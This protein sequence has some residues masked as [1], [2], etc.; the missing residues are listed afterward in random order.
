M[1]SFYCL[2]I[3]TFLVAL[4]GG[5]MAQVVVSGLVKNNSGKPIPSVSITLK[6]RN[7]LV[8]GFAIT[9]ASGTYRIGYEKASV[10]DTLT[11]EAVAVNYNRYSFP[12][13]TAKQVSDFV[14]SPAVTRLPDVVVKSRQMLRKE[15]DTL[16][17]DVESFST[18]Q[19]RTIGDVIKKLPGVEVS[20]KGEISVGGKPINRFYI[21]GDNLLDGKYNIATKSITNDMVAKIQVLENHQ[22]VNL[23]KDVVK[24]ESAAMNLVLKDKARIKLMGTGDAAAGLPDA[25]N[26]TVNA[27]M[28]RKKVKFINYFKLNNTGSDLSYET[29]NH[30]GNDYNPPAQLVNAGTAGT[31]ELSQRRYLFNNAALLNVNDLVTLASDLQLRI[32]MSYLADRQYQN[33]RVSSAFFLPS[34]TIRYVEQ[35]DSRTQINAFSSQFTLT[36]NKKNYYLNNITTIDNTGSD[37][38]SALAATAGNNISQQLGSTTTNL[39]NRFN[40][41]RKSAGGTVWEAYSLF[42]HVAD[43]A[44]LQVSPGL[45][46]AQFNA[47]NPYAAL[48]QY[49][50]VP[51]FYMDNYV[52]MKTAGTRIQQEY[53][54]GASYEDQQLM[55]TLQAQQL[56]GANGVVS[57]SFANRLQWNRSRIYAQADFTLT[58]NRVMLRGTFP[59][60]LQHTGYSSRMVNRFNDYPFSPRIFLK[61]SVGRESYFTLTYN[62]GNSFANIDQVYD[63]YIMRNYRSFY[64][65]SDLLPVSRQ[66][67]FSGAYYF[68]NT[69]RIFFVTVGASYSTTSL[70]TINDTRLSTLLQQSALVPFAGLSRSTQVFGSVSKYIFPFRTTL[71]AKLSWNRSLTNQ[72]LNGDLLDVTSDSYTAVAG[73]TTKFTEWLNIAYNGSYFTAGSTQASRAHGPVAGEPAVRKWRHTADMNLNLTEDFYLKFSAEIFRY[74]VP[75]TQDNDYTFL[76]AAATWKINR[77][78]TDLELSLTNIANIDTYSSASLSANSVLV[79]S[80]RIR[81]RMAMLK[82]Y[83]RF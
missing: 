5:A 44:T 1:R 19:D 21:D 28:F 61:Y 11:V 68:R 34:D 49:V 83:F 71:S 15:G 57:D 13:R 74:R 73:F 23:L 25:Y 42:T 45:Y 39:L 7:G 36:A 33:S 14:L 82:F 67:Q 16:N 58:V 37:V 38:Q 40:Y 47:G 8:L 24:S 17:Y 41:M 48:K 63:G 32:N 72:L 52:S 76:D 22:P 43:P 27:M 4:C 75:G 51:S 10:A 29:T 26:A 12:V 78:K 59:V 65:N 70:N 6:K 64:A 30:F 46:E 20:E 3:M 66:Q 81:P 80:Y 55:S 79:S 77:W 35:Q 31:P 69:L 2:C 18:K 54:V 50:T 60:S 62:Y 56:N 53:K 9:N